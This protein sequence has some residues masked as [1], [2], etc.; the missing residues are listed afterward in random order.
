MASKTLID[1]VNSVLDALG[2]IPYTWDYPMAVDG[3][4]FQ[5]VSTF[6]DQINREKAGDGILFAKPAAFVQIQPAEYTPLLGKI[7]TTDYI[8]RIHIV[9]IE[10]TDQA[11]T[12]D[13]NIS[14]FEYRDAV[15]R[16]LIN[17]TP[18]NSSQMMHVS[19]QQDADHTHVY[20]WQMDF[21]SA[22]IDVTGSIYDDKNTYII[23]LPANTVTIEIDERLNGNTTLSDEIF[24]GL[25]DETGI[26]LTL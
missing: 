8:Y 19:E 16:K 22:F 18:D 11:V 24:Q 2:S 26:P 1:A 7:S 23:E 14:I 13:R 17:F 20:V 10:M 4:L 25:T 6:N 5:F 3:K 15:K 21:K 9:G 12:L